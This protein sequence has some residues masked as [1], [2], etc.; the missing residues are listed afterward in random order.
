EDE[1]LSTLSHELR[2]PLQA[3]IGWAQILQRQPD[4]LTLDHA[5][6]A[7]TRN[8]RAQ[9]RLVEDLLDTSRILA[10][11][12]IPV[13][14]PTHM[15]DIVSSAVDALRPVASAKGVA[16]TFSDSAAAATV[17]GDAARLEQVMTNLLYNAVKF[18]PAG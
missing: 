12:V 4:E 2:T 13:W 10:G 11:K 3:V 8:A 16:L 1:F 9:A 5:V 6:E 15:A 17:S 7:I 14:S 18:T